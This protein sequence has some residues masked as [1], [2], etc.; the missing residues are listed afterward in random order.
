MNRVNLV[1]RTA[2]HDVTAF[3]DAA[4]NFIA[5]QRHI[6]LEHAGYLNPQAARSHPVLRSGEVQGAVSV[7]LGQN[8]APVVGDPTYSLRLIQGRYG[9]MP[10]VARV[11]P[12]L[13]QLAGTGGDGGWG[14][15]L[16]V[17]ASFTNSTSGAAVDDGTATARGGA[18]FLHILQAAATDTYSI[19]VEGATNVG[20]STGVVT[21]GTFALNASALGSE[22]LAI[23]GNIPQFVRFR[24]T[25]TGAAGNTVRI[26]ASLVRF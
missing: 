11:V 19:I 8:S 4:H 25:R 10:E 16:A 6:N 7:M 13:A 18:A 2:T 23:A 12:F 3:G 20:F 15:A 22:R 26:A 24:A 14:R 1:D 5:G 21:L 9:T 17:N